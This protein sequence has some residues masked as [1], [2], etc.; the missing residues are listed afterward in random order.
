ME[1]RHRSRRRGSALVYAVTA[2]VA[3]GGFC[4]LA[5]DWGRV[6]VVRSEL[7]QAADAAARYGAS[8]LKYGTSTARTYA[9]AAAGDNKAD[10][11]SVTLDPNLDVEF[12]T[13]DAAAKRFTVAGAGVTPDSIRVTARRTRARGNAI[14]LAFGRMIGMTS[15]DAAP[16]S[17]GT[18]VRRA[19]SVTSVSATANP[20]LAGMPNGTAANVG[21][22]A[23]NPDH[24][25][26]N[27]PAPVQGVTF[28]AGSQ[29]SFDSIVGSAKNGA[30]QTMVGA[31]GNAN[32]IVSNFAGAELGKSNLT[33]PINAVVGVFLN[34][35]NPTLLTTPPSLDFSTAASRNFTTLAPK[36]GQVFFIGDGRDASGNIQKFTIPD[37]ATR[38]YL[39]TMDGYEWNNNSGSYTVTVYQEGTPAVVR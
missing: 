38:L 7:Q 16:S 9:V 1:S 18:T 8:G 2:L 35:F 14:Q 22:P 32:Q 11:T 27:S 23:N 20:W 17:V 30:T 13:W 36:I 21:N 29:L 34:D 6:L 3:L 5:V 19:D 28:K 31:D 39:G 33:A 4:S 25:P 26:N 37:G 15:A 24:A 10:G 12:G